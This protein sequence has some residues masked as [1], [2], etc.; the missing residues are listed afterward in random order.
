MCKKKCHFFNYNTFEIIWGGKL[1]E[2]NIFGGAY[3][4]MPPCGE[5]TGDMTTRWT[6]HTNLWSRWRNLIVITEN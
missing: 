3:A 2:R 5:A 6:L 1:R 4:P